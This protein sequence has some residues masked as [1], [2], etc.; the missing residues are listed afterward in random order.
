[1][2]VLSAEKKLKGFKRLVLKEIIMTVFEKIKS[3]NIDELAEWFEENCTHDTDPC[4]TWY[5]K[6]YCKNCEA[7][8]KNDHKY[9]Y[10]ELNKNCKFFDNMP[11]AKETIKI[12][13]E[14]AE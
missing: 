10:C 5:D 14:S 11:S 2:L 3:M 1:M 9:A 8:N 12:W 6:T 13:L 4:L 7:I